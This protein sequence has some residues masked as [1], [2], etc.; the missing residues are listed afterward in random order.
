VNHVVPQAELLD[1][2]KAILQKINSKAPVAV[3]HCITAANASAIPKGYEEEIFGF[4]ECFSTEDV[5]EG[6][7]AFLEKRKA[8][9]KGK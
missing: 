7:T 1:K 5:K 6:T 8:N 3:G 4:G 2:C 9:F